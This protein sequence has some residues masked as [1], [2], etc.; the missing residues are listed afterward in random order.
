MQSIAGVLVIVADKAHKGPS[1]L[2]VVV[3][4]VTLCGYLLSEFVCLQVYWVGP[5]AGGILAG[6][7]YEFLFAG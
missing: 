4:L 7:L 3:E 1:W 5:I 2:I 6:L